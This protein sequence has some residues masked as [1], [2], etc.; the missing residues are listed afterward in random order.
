M[1]RPA[2]LACA[3]ILAA[4]GA[5]GA[6][7]SCDNEGLPEVGCDPSGCA[8]AAGTAIRVTVEGAADG[9]ARLSACLYSGCYAGPV[10][11]I[12][13]AGALR[14]YAAPGLPFSTDGTVR[15]DVALSVDLNTGYGTLLTPGFATPL[16]CVVE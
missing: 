15:A 10:A 6:G 4:T 7:L 14:A 16:R 9:G 2:R 5:Q 1:T 13:A 3:L 12:S 11:A 8:T